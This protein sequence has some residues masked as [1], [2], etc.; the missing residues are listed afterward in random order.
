MLYITSLL[1]GALLSFIQPRRRSVQFIGTFFLIVVVALLMGGVT[2]AHSFDTGAY[3]WMYNLSPETRRFEWGY[4]HLSY[5]FYSQGLPFET[6]RLVSYSIFL[7]ILYFAVR[8]FTPN[9][10]MFFTLFL[11]FPFFVEATQV[12]NFFMFSLVLFGTSFLKNKGIRP[13][14]LAWLFIACGVLFQTSGIIYLLVPLLCLIPLKTMVKISA[15]LFPLFSLFA[16]ISHY[17]LTNRLLASLLEFVVQLSGRS[18]GEDIVTLYSQGASFTRVLLY[19]LAFAAV[20][21]FV[22]Y[23]WDKAS[24]GDDDDLRKNAL[25]AI[26]MIGIFAIPAMAGS[27]DFERFFRN[28]I[29]ASLILLAMF[30]FEKNVKLISRVKMLPP[31]L[32]ILGLTTTAWRYWDSSST[33]RLQYLPYISQIQKDQ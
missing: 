14:L 29:T 2:S 17:F 20:Y 27:S 30:S 23:G 8:R 22:L 3:E 5:W 15:F 6:F 25:F 7:A 1:F 24:I 4:I 31:L 19:I 33:G 10:I 18:D 12:R 26:V 21:I 9:T 13:L 16:I 32:V 28:A 11:I